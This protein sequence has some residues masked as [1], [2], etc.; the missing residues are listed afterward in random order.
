MISEIQT[1][2]LACLYAGNARGG[3]P[4][5]EIV[6]LLYPSDPVEINRNN[7]Y[8]DLMALKGTG[9]LSRKF[10]TFYLTKRGRGV[11]EGPSGIVARRRLGVVFAEETKEEGG[12]MFI[13][14]LGTLN[15]FAPNVEIFTDGA[16]AGLNYGG[17][18]YLIRDNGREIV[19]SGSEEKTTNNR[20]ELM[21]AIKAVESLERANNIKLWSDSQYMLKGLTLWHHG[22]V[23]KKWIAV[24]NV[25]LWK[26]L[27]TAASMHYV[28]AYWV[29]GHNGHAENEKCDSMAQKEAEDL[30][31]SCARKS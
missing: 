16:C 6:K 14:A 19:N 1:D 4:L 17:W 23:K 24:A 8:T 27:L 15:K 2:I 7:V 10:D 31:I 21:A 25:D 26:R 5:D 9:H 20:M 30:A 11:S 13:G 3:K 18:S 29:R 12:Q 28:E 22:W